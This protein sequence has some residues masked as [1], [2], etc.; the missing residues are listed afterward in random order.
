MIS[1]LG[2]VLDF[3]VEK[4]RGSYNKYL[5]NCQRF[6]EDQMEELWV[7]RRSGDGAN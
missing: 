1:A 3:A 6:A 4:R 7:L 5:L 2:M